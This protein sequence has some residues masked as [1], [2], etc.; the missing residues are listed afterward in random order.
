MPQETTEQRWLGRRQFLT[1]A[2]SAP[3]TV[4]LGQSLALA[5]QAPKAA[6]SETIRLGFIGTGGMGTGLL[7]IFKKFKDV[8]IA[9]IADVYEPHARK[10]ADLSGQKP[11]VYSDFR[12]LLDRRDI[13]AVVVATPDHW[14]AHASIM[15][16]QAGKDIYCEKPLSHSIG[17]GK[18]MVA[19][20][21]KYQK[22]TQMGN[23]IHAGENYH[24]MAEIVQSGVLGQIT[25]CRVWMFADRDYPNG[26]GKPSD[27]PAPA[28]CDYNMWLGP[29]PARPFN[30]NRFTFNWRFFWDYG[31]GML[32]DF[33][34]HLVDPVHW[35]M[36]VDAPVSVTATGGR[37]GLKDNAETPDT[38]EV[39]W[40]YADNWD[41]H[42]T[43]SDVS[44]QG[45]LF[46]RSAGVL[47]EGTKGTMV[48]HYNDFK[49][50][51]EK[52]SEIV[53]PEKTLPR[54]PG[55]HREWINAIKSRQECSCRFAYGHRVTSVGNMGNIALKTGQKLEW[56]GKAERFTNHDQAN[57]YLMRAEYRKPWAFPTV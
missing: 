40:H 25:K 53:L 17:E 8:Q 4:S 29:A 45:K 28:G 47:F 24:R 30:Q 23:L 11:D 5:S 50:Y 51:A 7:N 37:Y 26:L 12:K 36:K 48:G 22:I 3:F 19:A 52:G 6:A 27:M 33:V 38:L 54:S 49:I 34:C 39:V 16:M 35:A 14:H 15:A 13:D 55:H 1:A 41:L 42:W 44:T 10:A 43:H 57:D 20:A 18:A 56:D 32:S 21:A 2:A 46:D 31:G 9:A